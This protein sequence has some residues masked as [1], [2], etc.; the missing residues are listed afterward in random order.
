MVA[1]T[2][3]LLRYGHITSRNRIGMVYAIA[4]V[5]TCITGFEI[6]PHFV[7]DKAHALAVATLVALAAAVAA[8][9]APLFG[10]VSL[11]V[12]T[13]AWS[14]T[15][16]FHWIAGVVET[17]TRLPRG[18]PLFANAEAAPLR[19]IIAVLCLLF[20]I[21]VVLQLRRLRRALNESD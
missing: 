3:S 20:V 12:S 16:L 17:S 5:L 18:R 6:V 21:G 7:L 9:Q 8:Q 13:L 19:G 4:T 10:R 2:A 14:A 11:Y 15:F 1:G